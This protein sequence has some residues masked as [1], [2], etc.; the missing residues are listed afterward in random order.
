MA[1]EIK[2]LINVTY[3]NGSL[4]D[5]FLPATVNIDQAAQGLH[6]PVVIVGTTQEYV[7][8]G[9]IST[10]GWIYGRNLDSSNYVTVGVSTGTTGSAM[11]NF[12]RIE[13]SEPFCFR[14]EPSAALAWKANSSAVKVQLK[15]LED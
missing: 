1:N 10:D 6:G 7:P 4:T 5:N 14:M 8:T 2:V 13:A 11:V 12:A 15:L 9:D 3:T